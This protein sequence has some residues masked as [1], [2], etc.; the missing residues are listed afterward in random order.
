MF[1]LFL[2]GVWAV[3]VILPGLEKRAKR[4]P[5]G[6][7]ILPVFPTMPLIAWGLACLLDSVHP[8]LGYYGIGALHIILAIFALSSV[9]KY[10]Y[11]IKRR[12]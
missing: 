3:V 12:A 5:G 1:T 8:G 6:V 7:S 10:G 2:F 9:A 11:E 4:Q